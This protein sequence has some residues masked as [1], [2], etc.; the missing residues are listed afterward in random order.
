[1]DAKDLKVKILGIVA[2]PIKGGNIEYLVR[3]ALKTSDGEGNVETE[4]IHLEDYRIEYCIGCDGC[5]KRI[6]KVMEETFSRYT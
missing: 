3:E 2:T 4:F 5:M 6:N 1:M